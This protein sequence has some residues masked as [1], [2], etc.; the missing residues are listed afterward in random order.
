MTECLFV[1]QSWRAMLETLETHLPDVVATSV[2]IYL[3]SEIE[4]EVSLCCSLHALLHMPT[5]A[6]CCGIIVLA[7]LAS[8][9]HS[10]T[11]INSES[12][13]LAIV[14]SD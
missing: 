1:T 14:R 6:L 13:F 7:T 4:C 3:D 5:A 8:V 12:K 9:E 10:P 11:P 2:P